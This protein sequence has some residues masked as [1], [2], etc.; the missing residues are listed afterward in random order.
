PLLKIWIGGYV[1]LANKYSYEKPSKTVSIKTFKLGNV[2]IKIDPEKFIEN[3][4]NIMFKAI[5]IFG[6]PYFLFVFF[7]F[8]TL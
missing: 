1:M 2:R 8:L 7:K 6:I 4:T 3:M 5:I